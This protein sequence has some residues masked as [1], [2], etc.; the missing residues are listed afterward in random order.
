MRVAP[1]VCGRH[2]SPEIALRCCPQELQAAWR[3]VTFTIGHVALISRASFHEPF[4]IRWE[5]PL[6]GGDNSSLTNE[7]ASRQ[8]RQVD[9]PYVA[10]CGAALPGADTDMVRCT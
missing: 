2:C 8:S 5:V 3:P 9:V 4:R 7:Q 1:A 6:G 10:T